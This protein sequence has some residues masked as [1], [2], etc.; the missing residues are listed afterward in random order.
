M[1]PKNKGSRL[2]G[3]P[4]QKD[5]PKS[6]ETIT[7]DDELQNS[8][9]QLDDH[10]KEVGVSNDDRKVVCDAQMARNVSLVKR[11]TEGLAAQQSQIT[12]LKE[13]NAQLELRVLALETRDK[14]S[15]VSACANTVLIWTK[16]ST[17]VTSQFI[18]DAVEAGGVKIPLK[19]FQ[20]ASIPTG[21]GNTNNFYKVTL[22]HDCKTALFKG[23]GHVDA[24]G[25][26][27]SNDVPVYLRKP[28]ADLEKA[29]YT[30]RSRFK[31]VGLKTK[32][33][34]KNLKLHISLRTNDHRE[35]FKLSDPKADSFLDVDVILKD[36]DPVPDKIPSC[37][38]FINAIVM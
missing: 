22:P 1:G 5:P 32:I 14:A 36:K 38:E 19:S 28:R 20:M 8:I 6:Q 34:L 29:A 3:P 16:N 24:S 25:Y 33:G 17:A 2:P 27:V 11:I 23:L 10:L 13:Q 15:Q 35:W 31:D 21:D 9:Q 26:N 18:K 30:L 12:T 7:I 4:G 37:R